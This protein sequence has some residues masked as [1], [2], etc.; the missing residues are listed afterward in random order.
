MKAVAMANGVPDDAIVLEQEAASTYENV[1]RT[2]RILNQH[3]WRHVLLVSSPYHMR[4][5]LLTWKKV[6]PE[7]VVAATPSES[8]FYAHRLG[9]SPDQIRAILH[10]YGGIIQYWR[11]GWI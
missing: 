9:A 7:I 10:E 3:G 6:A 5:A 8:Q 2:R 1:E 4:R 11:R